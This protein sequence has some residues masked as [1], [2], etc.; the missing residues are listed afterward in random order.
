MK[1]PRSMAFISLIF[2]LPTIAGCSTQT[3][4]ETAKQKAESDCRNQAPSETER[5]LE[6][7][8]QKSYENYEKERAGQK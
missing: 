4:Y 8:N 6:R 7:L 2:L 1:T 3:W 5:C